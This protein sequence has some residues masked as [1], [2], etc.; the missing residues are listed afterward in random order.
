VRRLTEYE[1]H[2]INEAKA[3]SANAL[4]KSAGEVRN[5]HDK[6]LAE[7]IS[8]KSGTPLATALRLVQARHRGVLYPDVELEFDR[9][10]VV[11]VGA[12]LADAD[13]YVGET[14]ADPMEGVDYG[15]CKA[16]VMRGDD[17][18]LF[19][20]SFAHGGSVYSRAR[21]CTHRRRADRRQ[22]AA[23]Q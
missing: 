10:G 17:G 5:K 4:G 14:L 6:E 22:R 11:T 19:I 9:L 18:D 23:I 13:R 7:K 3:A 16:M 1:R 21:S 8:A 12:V 15:R 2:R 20:H